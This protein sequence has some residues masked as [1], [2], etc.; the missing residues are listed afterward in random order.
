MNPELAALRLALE[1]CGAPASLLLAGVWRWYAPDLLHIALPG[2]RKLAE[3]RRGLK[4]SRELFETWLPGV[5][6]AVV[7]LDPPQA[8]G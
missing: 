2:G 7:P 3:G 5:D 4:G 1:D 6:V 8:V